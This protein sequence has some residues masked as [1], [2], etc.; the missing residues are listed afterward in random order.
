MFQ[1]LV[2]ALQTFGVKES[3]LGSKQYAEA[4]QTA[5]HRFAWYVGRMALF[6][7]VFATGGVEVPEE[8][9]EQVARQ[10]EEIM[11]LLED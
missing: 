1:S 2:D 11:H 7:V 6:L 8:K 3:E 10:A 4:W 5:S 9:M